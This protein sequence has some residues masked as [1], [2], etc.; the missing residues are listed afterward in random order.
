MPKH[1]FFDLDGTLAESKQN[2]KQD[3]LEELAL[4]SKKYEIILVSGAELF[5]MLIQAPI[6]YAVFMSQ[7][8]NQ[9]YS[10]EKMI[11]ENKFDNKDNVLEHINKCARE[12]DVKIGEDMI[13]DRGSQ[14]SFSF[15]G[16][17]AP[18]EIKKK[19]DPLRQIRSGLLDKYPFNGC[20]IGGTTCLDYVPHTKGENIKRYL[21]LKNIN[22]DE[23]VYFGDAFMKH[24]NDK[25][26]EGII[27]T[28]EVANPQELM[29]LLKEYE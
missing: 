19:F 14:I 29:L 8:G 18:L 3:M 2:L 22:A 7:N 13:D 1:L 5:R 23:C 9:V 11:W 24:G 28:V 16:H 20:V 26:V 17:H 15:V 4:L 25:T 12:L 21:E 10:N 6:K 27:K